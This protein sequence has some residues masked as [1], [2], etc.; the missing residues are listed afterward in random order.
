MA[1]VSGTCKVIRQKGTIP[2]NELWCAL[3]NGKQTIQTPEGFAPTGLHILAYG[4]EC[5]EYRL[6]ILDG[7]W[8]GREV[9]FRCSAQL[10][11][12]GTDGLFYPMTSL[13]VFAG[14]YFV[15]GI[16]IETGVTLAKTKRANGK[17]HYCYSFDEGTYLIGAGV[18]PLFLS[19][20]FPKENA[21]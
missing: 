18:D 8:A 21:K 9:K 14:V 12:V 16:R 13:S 17:H 6:R 7:P 2:L 3:H 19:V 10:E 1:Y 4:M 20:R 15:D 5:L 11:F